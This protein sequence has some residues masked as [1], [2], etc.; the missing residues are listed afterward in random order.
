M[1]GRYMQLPSQ[2]D[3]PSLQAASEKGYR[4]EIDERDGVQPARAM[5]M[6]SVIA[7]PQQLQANLA[8]SWSHGWYF[9]DSQGRLSLAL[10]KN[11]LGPL[12]KDQHVHGQI[13]LISAE[14]KSISTQ[15]QVNGRNAPSVLKSNRFGMSEDQDQL[16]IRPRIID[17]D[18]F[19]E[20]L[21]QPSGPVAW[22]YGSYTVSQSGELTVMLD[23][24]SF[25]NLPQGS[26]ISTHFPLRTID[27]TV[28]QMTA[29]ISGVN[30]KPTVSGSIR[31]QEIEGEQTVK[32]AL[33]DPDGALQSA[34]LANQSGNW[35]HGTFRTDGNAQLHLSIMTTLQLPQGQV[36]DGAISLRSVDQSMLDCKVDI[37]GRNTSSTLSN[38][39]LVLDRDQP[40]LSIFP[41]ITDPDGPQEAMLIPGQCGRW[42]YGTYMVTREGELSVFLDQNLPGSLP[43]RAMVE[44]A[45][46]LKTL[47]QTR[48]Q[49]SIE[50]D[51]GA[52]LRTI[53]IALENQEGPGPGKGPLPGQETDI[54]LVAAG[55]AVAEP[56]AGSQ[57]E[58]APTPTKPEDAA[59][60]ND[61][62][63]V[64]ESIGKYL[65]PA[66]FDPGTI[67][68]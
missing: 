44:N 51:Q 57:T 46:Q 36:Q 58:P 43:R 48:H 3:K 42:Q 35:T 1:K 12:P 13:E 54:S 22:K 49:I 14:G 11:L 21:L 59:S 23:R 65:A 40:C 67:Y 30:D 66:E 17:P 38:N 6:D 9:T 41:E 31:L 53:Q 15:V 29:E 50:L 24:S 64:L 2:T 25:A 20:A 5:S 32:L 34:L 63:A 18:G 26:T 52:G 4:F 68:G 7:V 37:L 33:H 16:I 8:G 27:G 47:D 61:W 62:Y 45:F 19:E 39:P 60:S 55:P 56:L 10:D 28:H